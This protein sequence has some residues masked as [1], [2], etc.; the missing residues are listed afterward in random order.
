MT[1]D[2]WLALRM[3][4]PPPRL[5]TRMREVL[6][7]HVAS[8]ASVAPTVCLDAACE[9]LR[10]LVERPNAGREAALDLLTA[11]ALVTYAC[12]AA[13]GDLETLTAV[14]RHSMQRLAALAPVP[15]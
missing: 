6:G 7:T 11:D 5:R 8:D 10:S 2:Q 1:V 14:A 4:E 12:E 3:P 9:L 13:S 15:S